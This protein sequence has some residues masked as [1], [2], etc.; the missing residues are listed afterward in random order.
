M[1]KHG[2]TR[3]HVSCVFHS[4]LQVSTIICSDIFYFR[5]YIFIF[6]HRSVFHEAVCGTTVR[7]YCCVLCPRTRARPETS[8]VLLQQYCRGKHVMVVSSRYLLSLGDLVFPRE[9][10]LG[11]FTRKRVLRLRLLRW[12]LRLGATRRNR[13]RNACTLVQQY[14]S[15]YEYSNKFPYY[16]RNKFLPKLP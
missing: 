11:R 4:L 13:F 7:T 8:Q 1:F 16:N 6:A 5:T 15:I 3:A 9:R 12:L 2:Y 14:S 10:E